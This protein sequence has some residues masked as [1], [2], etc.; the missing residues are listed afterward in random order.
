MIQKRRFCFYCGV[1]LLFFSFQEVRVAAFQVLV[2]IARVY[3]GFLP[4][5][6]Q[7]LFNLSLKVSNIV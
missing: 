3:Y 1:N 4:G 2:E 6:M 7:A 5:Y